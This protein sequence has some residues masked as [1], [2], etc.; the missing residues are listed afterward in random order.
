[1]DAPLRIGISSCFFHADPQRPVFKG[2]TLLYIEQSLAHWLMST[3]AVAV[4]LPTAPTSGQQRTM[5]ELID[6]LVLHG[7]ADVAPGSY[8]ETPLLPEWG[9]DAVRDAYEIELLRACM[10]MDKPILGVCRGAQLIN[11]GLG[12]TL[13]Q[14]IGTQRP[15]AQPHRDWEV[16]DML[17]H[18]VRLEPGGLLAQLYP[19]VTSTTHVNSVHH[20]GV[21]NLGRGLQVQATS[22][23]GMIEAILW[24][25]SRSYVLGVQWHPE[26][27]DPRDS[28]LL[29]SQPILENYLREVAQRR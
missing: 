3:G 21:K 7:G 29:S 28:S 1:M 15:E 9:G 5:L 11:V 12:G 13:Y 24:T 17:H 22:D 20:Q 10:D 25:E 4:A 14:D 23:D 26:Y 2:K 6:G 8:G 18:P 27:H 16:Y 19:H